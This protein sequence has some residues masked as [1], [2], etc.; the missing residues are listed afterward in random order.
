[1]LALS[2]LGL[3]PLP[4]AL[5][6]TAPVPSFGAG[7]MCWSSFY[8]LPLIWNGAAWAAFTSLGSLHSS[9]VDDDVDYPI[10]DF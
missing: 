8:G 6:A 2:P 3:P 1:M 4:V 9:T 7:A 10:Y 5:G